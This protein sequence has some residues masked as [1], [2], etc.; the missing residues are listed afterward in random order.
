MKT[1]IVVKGL[2]WYTNFKLAVPDL[3]V[4]PLI[5]SKI[6]GNVKPEPNTIV[7][8]DRFW[9]VSK[10]IFSLRLKILQSLMISN[11]I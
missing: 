1:Q 2:I 8:N 3:I 11:K 10:K 7:L 6:I 4:T 5:Q 9:L